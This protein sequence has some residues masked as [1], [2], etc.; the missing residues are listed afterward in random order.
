LASLDWDE[1]KEYKQYCVQEDKLRMVIGFI[2]SYYNVNSPSDMYEILHQ[3]D[4]G[5]MMMRKRAINDAEGLEYFI[6]NI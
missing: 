3:D 5:N 4:I 1:Y 6:F 2:K